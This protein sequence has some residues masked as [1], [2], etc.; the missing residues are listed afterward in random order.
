MKTDLQQVI[1]RVRTI[2]KYTMNDIV[3]HK[4]ADIDALMTAAQTT[5]SGGVE[6]R[7]HAAN[8]DTRKLQISCSGRRPWESAKDG[9][10]VRPAQPTSRRKAHMARKGAQA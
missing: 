3:T 6:N 8:C 5:L 10:S 9:S 1:A 4:R 2:H 7:R